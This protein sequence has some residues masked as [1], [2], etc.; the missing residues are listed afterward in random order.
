[1]QAGCLLP[2]PPLV[3]C[4]ARQQASTNQPKRI[5]SVGSIPN[6]NIIQDWSLSHEHSPVPTPTSHRHLGPPPPHTHTHLHASWVSAIPPSMPLLPPALLETSLPPRQQPV[7][8]HT[9][10]FSNTPSPTFMQAGC[11]LPHP[12][13]P[14]LPQ[15]CWQPRSHHLGVQGPCQ[16]PVKQQQHR[17][18][19]NAATAA[20]AAAA[21]AAACCW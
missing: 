14:S 21:A 4:H 19:A 5:T 16:Q 20:A 9:H 8:Q 7:Q 3:W 18:M 17:R 6:T 10:S 2:P 13:G 12:P 1:M 11:L 15:H